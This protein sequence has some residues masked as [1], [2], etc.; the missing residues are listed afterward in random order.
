[1]GKEMY[2]EMMEGCESPPEVL[3]VTVDLLVAQRG[4]FLE[5]VA[6]IERHLDEH[7]LLHNRTRPGVLDRKLR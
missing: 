7:G 5:M 3:L 4:H 1:M 6:E 2:R